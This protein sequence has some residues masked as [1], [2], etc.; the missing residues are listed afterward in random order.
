MIFNSLND[1]HFQGKWIYIPPDKIKIVVNET[2]DS[3]K[4][5]VLF[6]V[7]LNHNNRKRRKEIW[8]K[9]ALGIEAIKH[10]ERDKVEKMLKK[11]LE[12]VRTDR[13]DI[14]DKLEDDGGRVQ[15]TYDTIAT[16][17][18]FESVNNTVLT[19]I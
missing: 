19:S 14:S 1:D 10:E 8:A 15:I 4:K 17:G 9:A 5:E 16:F 3:K 18:D 12:T 6:P 7:I 13:K 11:A 2:V